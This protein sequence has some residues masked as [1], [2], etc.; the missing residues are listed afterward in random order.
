[1]LWKLLSKDFAQKKLRKWMPKNINQHNSSVE[2]L[3]ED[4]RKKADR[5]S[6][7][8][9][10]MIK[11]Y[12]LVDL[13]QLESSPPV[14]KTLKV[15]YAN[16]C[17]FAWARYKTGSKTF[18]LS[19]RWMVAA[20]SLFTFTLAIS[21]SQWFDRQRVLDE[22]D[23]KGRVRLER[24]L[25]KRCHVPDDELMLVALDGFLWR[26]DFGGMQP[27]MQ[28]LYQFD[29]ILDQGYD[30]F[31][32]AHND[33]RG[34]SRS[35]LL[36]NQK[37]SDFILYFRQYPLLMKRIL[38]VDETPAESLVRLLRAK[39]ELSYREKVELGRLLDEAP[40][41]VEFG[42]E[43][44]MSIMEAVSIMEKADYGVLGELRTKA[45]SK[46]FRLLLSREI[47]ELEE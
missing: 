18:K 46:V 22:L 4:K 7:Q 28:Q 42:L 5:R 11:R 15:D 45:C 13:K 19:V 25:Q 12:T 38:Q 43:P 14:W 21:F 17:A 26:A 23:K 30:F 20:L 39:N 2:I 6:L 29:Q 27:V 35:Y 16:K 34:V 24:V 36:K 8:S 1:M 3:R 47:E 32:F 9:A 44:D 31:N 33:L 40:G 41:L 10:S 37:C